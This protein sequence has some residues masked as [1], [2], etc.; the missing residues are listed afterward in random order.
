MIEILEPLEVR[1]GD[2]TSVDE[3]VRCANNTTAKEDLF[4]C[5][6]GRTIGTLK[7]C[8]DLDV[9]SIALVE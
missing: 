7:D 2:T 8:L 4:S 5:M 3:H 9:L 6:S 1:A